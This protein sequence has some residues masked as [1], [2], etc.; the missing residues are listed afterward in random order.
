MGRAS[1]TIY[2]IHFDRPYKHARHY[3]GSA[4]NLQ[5]RLERHKAG[6][7]ARLMEVVCSNG[8]GFKVVRTW[9]GGRN[10][11]R[12]LKN[13]KNTPLLCPTCNPSTWKANARAGFRGGQKKMGVRG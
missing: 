12:L 2:L 6:Q 1:R 11:E 10:E 4:D 3:M 7:G 13:K 8:I 9:K 5:E